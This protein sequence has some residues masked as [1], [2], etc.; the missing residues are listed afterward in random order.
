MVNPLNRTRDFVVE[1]FAEL[2][3]SSWPNRSEL[4]DSTVLVLV[5]VLVL[6]LFVAFADFIF[7]KAVAVLTRTI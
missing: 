4:M 2:K 3:K 7:L 6:G 5:T 1:V